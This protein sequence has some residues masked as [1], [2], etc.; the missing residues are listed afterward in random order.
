MDSAGLPDRYAAVQIGTDGSPKF[1]KMV[2]VRDMGSE[3]G[4]DGSMAGIDDLS[5]IFPT[6]TIL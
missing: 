2:D 6:L 5:C 1:R 4:G 3:H